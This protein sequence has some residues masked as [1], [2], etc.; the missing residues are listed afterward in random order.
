MEFFASEVIGSE[1]SLTTPTLKK[2]V[3]FKQTSIILDDSQEDES[4]SNE[5]E[6]RKDEDNRLH[7]I[8]SKLLGTGKERANSLSYIYDH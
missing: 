6:K 8:R 5:A 7:S 1:D 2:Y 3:E 4:S